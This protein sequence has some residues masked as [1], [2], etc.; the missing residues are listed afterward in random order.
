[1]II[2]I[3]M[4]LL[5]LVSCIAAACLIASAQ[6]SADAARAMAALEIDPDIGV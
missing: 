5:F 4:G 3:V 6:N 1:M 2:A